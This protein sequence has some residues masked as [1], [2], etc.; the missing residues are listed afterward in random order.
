MRSIMIMI[1]G[2]SSYTLGTG[3]RQISE[4]YH[5]DEDQLEEAPTDNEPTEAARDHDQPTT[6]PWRRDSASLREGRVNGQGVDLKKHLPKSQYCRQR[7]SHCNTL[8]T[9][10]MPVNH[11]INTQV[12]PQTLA[13]PPDR[14]NIGRR[15]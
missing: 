11:A 2:C 8:C 12:Q 5:G 10:L 9:L 3:A 15:V 7:A 4:K 1:K 14:R 6:K 13:K